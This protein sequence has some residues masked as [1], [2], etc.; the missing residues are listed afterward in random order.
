MQ[1]EFTLQALSHITIAISL[2]AP[3][4]CFAYFSAERIERR[5][6]AARHRSSRLGGHR[7]L[8]VHCADGG[9]LLGEKDDR[10]GVRLPTARHRID[11][12]TS[13]GDVMNLKELLAFNLFL[14]IFDGTASYFI[15]SRGEA[16]LNPLVSAEIDAWGLL[17]AL[18]S[19]KVLT[20]ALLVI[21]YSLGRYRPAL[22][23]R[24]LTL[25]AIVY[26]ALGFYLVLHLL[27]T[28]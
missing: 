15:L 11:F 28:A 18:V 22:P 17:W 2:L 3:S 19:W 27:H 26:S 21:L 1:P 23:L 8:Y 6:T 14:Q 13:P 25:V 12:A 16:E 5:G 24:G 20:C 10:A 7:G 9:I 4:L